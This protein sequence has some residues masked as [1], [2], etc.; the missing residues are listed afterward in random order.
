MYIIKKIEPENILFFSLK[1]IITEDQGVRALKELTS[2]VRTLEKG[3]IL[4]IDTRRFKPASYKKAVEMTKIALKLMIIKKPSLIMRIGPKETIKFLDKAYV[5]LN[6]PISFSLLDSDD[7]ENIIERINGESSAGKTIR[8]YL[9][10]F[11]DGDLIPGEQS[12]NDID[13]TSFALN[14]IPIENK[15]VS[16]TASAYSRK[17]RKPYYRFM[18]MPEP[19]MN[20]EES[21]N[22]ELMGENEAITIGK[23]DY[24]FKNPGKY[25]VSVKVSSTRDSWDSP[26]TPEAKLTVF[27]RNEQSQLS[28]DEYHDF[29]FNPETEIEVI[30]NKES[31]SPIVRN[32]VIYECD[33]S[34]RSMVIGYV[35]PET[36]YG[37]KFE[38]MD[39]AFNCFESNGERTRKG[40]KVIAN[41]KISEYPITDSKKTEA[42]L[43]R[44]ELP[45]EPIGLRR[46]RQFFRCDV[47]AFTRYIEAEI[48]LQGHLFVSGQDFSIVDLSI[49]GVG[50]N[51]FEDGHLYRIIKD[52]TE[53]GETGQIDFRL[54]D[55]SKSDDEPQIVTAECQIMRK[56]L[57]PKESCCKIGLRFNDVGIYEGS[58]LSHFITILQLKVKA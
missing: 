51:F 34:A 53:I 24:T 27:V 21:E 14:G 13:I 16:F 6:I 20:N 55:P 49:T 25:I 4:L 28:G 22:W 52:L 36:E 43:V 29:P 42:L 35:N 44:F 17:G 9:C 31:Y 26:M 45:V 50:L 30:L 7:Y 2:T 48:E 57:C 37:L 41:K 23:C 54:Y 1:G 18:F 40:V 39:I 10:H 32:S 12:E 33:L 3:Y 47:Y 38:S 46:D 8:E 15:K 56:S 58:R 5:E 19:E 11:K